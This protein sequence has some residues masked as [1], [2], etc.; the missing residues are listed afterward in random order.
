MG[1]DPS[2][3]LNVSVARELPEPE[4]LR[5]LLLAVVGNFTTGAADDWQQPCALSMD[6]RTGL[7]SA[8]APEALASLAQKVVLILL[9]AAQF[10]LWV[11]EARAAKAP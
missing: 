9:V 1:V 8:R 3:P 6:P 4:L 10:K 5:L 11:E 2:L 7:W